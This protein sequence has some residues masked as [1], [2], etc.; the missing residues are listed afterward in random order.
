LAQQE[1]PVRHRVALHAIRRNW[2]QFGGA[3]RWRKQGVVL[4]KR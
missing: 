3:I 2:H 4:E 1:A